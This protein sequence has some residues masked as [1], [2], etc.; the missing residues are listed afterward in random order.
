VKLGLR[1]EPGFVGEHDRTTRA[2]IPVHIS[3]RP[4]DLGA[5]VEGML[6]FARGAAARLDAVVAAAVLAFGFVYIHPFED[7]NGRLHRYLIHHVLARRHFHPPGIVFPISAAILDEIVAYG[8][9]LESYSS[10]LL[11]VIQ[12]KSTPRGNVQVS[13]DTADF[14][15]FFDATPHAEFL[16]RCVERTVTEDLP[17]ET[18][19]LKRYDA[20]SRTIKQIVDMP[21]STV[22]LLFRFLRPN[23]G[24]LSKRARTR[25][26]ADLTEDETAQV[27]AAFAQTFGPES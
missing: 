14:Y 21:D 24:R 7:G 25:E 1:D 3:A 5:L 17:A 15:R 6:E 19:Y 13:N 9:V 12:W 23:D 27:E 2:P 11:P 10:R 18:D 26:F 4:E 22:D 16:Y 8:Q 20:F